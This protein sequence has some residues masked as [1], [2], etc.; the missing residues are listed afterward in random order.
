MKAILNDRS[1]NASVLEVFEPVES[2]DLSR[3]EGEG[4]SQASERAAEWI[5]VPLE[6]DLRRR[7]RWEPVAIRHI[8]KQER[9]K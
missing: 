7:H 3:F 4:G 8:R 2:D 6:R 9:Q 5:D 1:F